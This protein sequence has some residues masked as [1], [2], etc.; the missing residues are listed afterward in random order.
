MCT[1]QPILTAAADYE[2]SQMSLTTTAEDNDLQAREP[3]DDSVSSKVN[4][5]PSRHSPMNI[6]V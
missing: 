5:E 4:Y 3:L 1:L 2:E 6:A